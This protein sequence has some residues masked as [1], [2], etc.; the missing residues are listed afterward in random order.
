MPGRPILILTLLLFPGLQ[1]AAD[2]SYRSLT[3]RK[4]AN[5]FYADGGRKFRNRRI[6]IHAPASTVLA[7]GEV[8]HTRTGTR[9]LRFQNRN[10]PLLVRPR[11]VYLRKVRQRTSRDDRVCL[12]GTV[13]ECPLQGAGQ[14]VLFVHTLKKAP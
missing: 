6:H 13:R 12:K 1:A 14:S 11:N 5:A 7:K 8:I 10:V 3:T 9:L 2:V 4:K